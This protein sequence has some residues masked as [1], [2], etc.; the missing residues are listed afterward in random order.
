M[1]LGYAFYARMLGFE[2]CITSCGYSKKEYE[3]SIDAVSD[4]DELKV[5]K[6]AFSPY[7]HLCWQVPSE[8]PKTDSP[9][10]ST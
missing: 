4:L 2:L 5:N 10:A 1:D 3:H 9:L 6:G 7:S 8:T